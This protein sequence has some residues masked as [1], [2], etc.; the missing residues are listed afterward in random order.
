MLPTR[1]L[2]ALAIASAASLALAQ[3]QP[4][5]L[6]PM[7]IPG[8]PGQTM[9][10]QP[11]QAPAPKLVNPVVNF[12]GE[13]S[14]G[15]NLRS[16]LTA[17][18]RIALD[19]VTEQRY[20]VSFLPPD[21]PGSERVTAMRFGVVLTV[22][23]VE[24]T[25]TL[26]DLAFDKVEVDMTPST[27]DQFKV[28]SA[29]EAPA[30]G[31][32]ARAFY[33]AAKQLVA[34]RLTVKLLPDNT[35]VDVEGEDE[36][37]KLGPARLMRRVLEADGLRAWL[38]PVL[39]LRPTMPQVVEGT[40]PLTVPAGNWPV[41]VVVLADRGRQDVREM[42]KVDKTDGPIT[43][44]RGRAR[45]GGAAGNVG[46]GSIYLR[47]C[48]TD[49]R[50]DW[51]TASGSLKAGSID[52]AVTLIMSMPDNTRQAMSTLT[53]MTITPRAAAAPAAPAKGG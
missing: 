47:D 7:P 15:L 42:R 43:T 19:L 52:D 39:S 8:P 38:G 21:K 20:A 37:L 40:P 16:A 24:P 48:S 26:A 10:P 17:G 2:S 34:T 53:T 31:T 5:Q 30:A 27:G 45:I 32:P 22:K 23:S 29:G 28:S 50:F 12:E 18:Q 4:A 51:D 49:S 13:P 1:T 9:P 35:I 46:A 44:V 36:L 11:P 14:L 25:Q 3:G 6:T 41:T 33:D